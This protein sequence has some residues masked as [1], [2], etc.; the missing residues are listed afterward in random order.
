MLDTLDYAL[1]AAGCSAWGVAKAGPVDARAVSLY[2]NWIKGG[3]NGDMGYLNRY[4]DVRDNPTFLLDGTKS[5]IVCAFPYYSPGKYLFSTYA[6]GRDYHE[7]LRE[8]LS[9]VSLL[10]SERYNATCRICVDSAPLRERYWAVRA[11]LGFIGKNN[12]LI[13]PKQGS[14]HFLVSI[15]TT[16]ELPYNKSIIATQCDKCD[17]CLHAC[18]GQALDVQGGMDARKCLSYLTIENK[19]QDYFRC[20]TLYG[21]DVCQQVCP[22]NKGIPPTQITDFKPRQAVVELTP[23]DILEMPKE[24]FSTIFSHSAVKRIGLERLRR[25]AQNL[26]A[27]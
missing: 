25:N 10:L 4:H 9:P 7:V 16:L 26:T 5:L 21:C 2:K 13:L 27:K 8:R 3:C 22:F 24:R 18:P 1:R 17:R 12:Q 14:Y 19:S 6:L 20:H 15:L 11:G 23:Q